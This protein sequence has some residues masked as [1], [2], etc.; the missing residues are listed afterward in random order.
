[1]SCL[2]QRNLTVTP[3]QQEFLKANHG[4]YNN[5]ELARMLHISYNIVHNNL[6]LM[7]LVKTKF[8]QGKVV[9]MEGYF[10][11]DSFGK[12]YIY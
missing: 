2:R 8:Q 4:K 3:E 11:V 1:M 10:D 12:Q 7:G 9:T 5:V 6:R